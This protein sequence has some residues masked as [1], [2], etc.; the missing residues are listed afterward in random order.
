MS[1][2][3]ANNLCLLTKL[4]EILTK[5]SHKCTFSLSIIWFIHNKK[6]I[7][8]FFILTVSLSL[9][10]SVSLCTL[11]LSLLIFLLFL[12]SPFGQLFS[13]H[14][15]IYWLIKNMSFLDKENCISWKFLFCNDVSMTWRYWILSYLDLVV[16]AG[17]ILV[18]DTCM[19]NFFSS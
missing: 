8:F 12:S 18:S 7:M 6:F 14:I 5:T 9:S 3:W 15:C 19:H 13:A 11:F 2:K 4:V 1:V 17:R 16:G 10:L